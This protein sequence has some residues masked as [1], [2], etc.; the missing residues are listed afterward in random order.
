MS[1]K[2]EESERE[3]HGAPDIA[4]PDDDEKWEKH[5]AFV[6]A[7]VFKILELVESK[8]EKAAR[9]ARGELQT[10]FLNFCGFLLRIGLDEKDSKAKEWAGRFLADVFF[11]IGKHVGKIRIEK[12]Y[13]QLIKANAAFRSEKKKIGRLR[14]DVLYPGV[15]LA[16]VK[17]ELKAAERYRKRLILLSAINNRNIPKAER[18]RFGLLK[19]WKEAAMKEGIPADYLP[20]VKFPEFRPKTKLRWWKFLWPLIKKNNPDF[21]QDSRS[22][23]FPTRGISSTLVGQ[24]IVRNSGRP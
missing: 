6:M 11:S 15:V 1:D 16:I 2:R 23:A 20:L 14:A 3:V 21:M 18:Q 13:R 8:H 9:R 12:P 7:W 5:S 4:D 24:F 19:D 22:G 17:R 10:L